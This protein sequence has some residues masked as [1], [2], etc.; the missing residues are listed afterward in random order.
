[1]SQRPRS[2]LSASEQ[3]AWVAC[4]V[5]VW[6]VEAVGFVLVEGEPSGVVV[7]AGG[8]AGVQAAIS[9]HKQGMV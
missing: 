9:T 4:D 2:G 3:V 6:L 1:M 7:L 5:P 8:S